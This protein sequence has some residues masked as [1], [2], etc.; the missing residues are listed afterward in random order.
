MVSN[1]F[2]LSE[3]D[4]RDVAF[5]DDF[6]KAL[7]FGHFREDGHGLVLSA[8]RNRA[9]EHDGI[10]LAGVMPLVSIFA[11]SPLACS[12]EVSSSGLEAAPCK[13]LAAR[14]RG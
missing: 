3:S 1:S 11:V 4:G 10:E 9:G 2:C 5:D 13:M 6:L 7:I 8:S 14:S 12:R